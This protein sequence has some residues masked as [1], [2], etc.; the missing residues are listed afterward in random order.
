[1]NDSVENGWKKSAES[2][3]DMTPPCP[4]ADAQM[5]QQICIDVEHERIVFTCSLRRK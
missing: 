1:M 4:V 2:S 3:D 5:N